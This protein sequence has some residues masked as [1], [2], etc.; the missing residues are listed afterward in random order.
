MAYDAE[1]KWTVEDDSVQN[2]MKGLMQKDNPYMQTART[3]GMQT[4]N[5]RGLANSSMGTQA[6]EMAAIQSALPIASQDA[7]QIADKNMMKMD[8]TSKE[9]IAMMNVAAHDR[10]KSMAGIANAENAYASMFSTIGNNQDL[11]AAVRDKYLSHIGAIRDSSI[12]MVEQMYGIDLDWASTATAE[13]AV[14]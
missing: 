2:Q 14:A 9:D 8:A 7:K 12:N 5:R 10:E 3:S 11:P 1:G 6:G 13:D 4:A